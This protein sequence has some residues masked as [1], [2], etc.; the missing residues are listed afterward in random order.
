MTLSFRPHFEGRIERL[1]K[2]DILI[3]L[4]SSN[5]IIASIALKKST[6]SKLRKMKP[7]EVRRF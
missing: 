3:P 6:L 2:D 4:D 7:S 1:I 5:Q